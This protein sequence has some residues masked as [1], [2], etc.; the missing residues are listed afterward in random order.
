M[1]YANA[2]DAWVVSWMLLVLVIDRILQNRNDATARKGIAKTN[3]INGPSDF[4]Y[5][6]AKKSE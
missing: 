4:K 2:C 6:P 3:Y 5:S 1:Q